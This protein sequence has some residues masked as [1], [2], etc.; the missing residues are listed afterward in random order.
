MLVCEAGSTRAAVQPAAE[1]D[2]AAEL[3]RAAIVEHAV[4]D[5]I[6]R[7]VT[8]QYIA[9]G[10]YTERPYDRAAWL[11]HSESEFADALS[12]HDES[13]ARYSLVVRGTF[14][15][16]RQA[17]AFQAERAPL[18]DQRNEFIDRFPEVWYIS[19]PD[20]T[21]LVSRDPSSH[22]P[23][24]AGIYPRQDPDRVNRHFRPL[25]DVRTLPAVSVDGL[26]ASIGDLD[27]VA[28][29]VSMPDETTVQGAVTA[30]TKRSGN[31]VLS[32]WSD[33][34][35]GYQIVR[36]MESELPDS[37]L[38]QRV[39]VPL[40]VSETS[41]SEHA[42]VWL[43]ATTHVRSRRGTFEKELELTFEWTAVNDRIDSSVFDWH[44]WDLPAGSA[45]REFRLGK[46]NMFTLH[47]FGLPV[48]IPLNTSGEVSAFS[49]QQFLLMVNC[50]LL[51][52]IGGFA[53]VWLAW[54]LRTR[55]KR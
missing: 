19:L 5:N 13:G 20:R 40:A 18:S 31:R 16:D 33:A 42:G 43:P 12:M 27:V 55:T 4:A 6:E 10:T 48:E 52:G 15:F 47:E 44:E 53:T 23:Y 14:D 22:R 32:W 51:A 29:L 39:V 54:R 37:R 46:E 9:R 28:A 49:A 45:V 11:R 30:G 21:I 25:F 34:E 17:F 7:I 2:A 38:P 41:W 26:E 50:S 36:M 24:L 3:D 8:G 35:Q 1:V